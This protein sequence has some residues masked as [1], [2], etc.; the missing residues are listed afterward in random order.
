MIC[1]C[2]H[3]KKELNGFMKPIR[4]QIGPKVIKKVED[5]QEDQDD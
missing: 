2:L 1:F 4:V 5:T 3:E